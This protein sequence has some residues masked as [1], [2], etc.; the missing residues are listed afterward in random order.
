VAAILVFNERE[1][2]RPAGFPV[3]RHDHLRRWSDA[4]EIGTKIGFSSGVRQIADEQTDGQ[5]T[6]S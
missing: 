4:A 2:T 3:D 6:L 1:A 5:S